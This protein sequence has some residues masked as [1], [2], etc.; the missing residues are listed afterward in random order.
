[1]EFGGSFGDGFVLSLDSLFQ[2]RKSF[3]VLCRFLI[4]QNEWETVFSLERSVVSQEE[5]N[6]GF[7]PYYS[8]DIGSYKGVDVG[9]DN[10][11]DITKSF[12]EAM[13]NAI[14]SGCFKEVFGEL[15]KEG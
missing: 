3:Q 6:D 13:E 1:M 5:I 7:Q 15:I 11:N 2:I 4:N 9:E 10:W 12:F 14:P 8:V